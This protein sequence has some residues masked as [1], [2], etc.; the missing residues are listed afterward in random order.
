MGFF[1]KLKTFFGGTNNTGDTMMG[2]GGM[3]S[4]QMSPG[5]KVDEMERGHTTPNNA[6]MSGETGATFQDEGENVNEKIL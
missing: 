6:D 4:Q 3:N 1:D 2:E 5:E